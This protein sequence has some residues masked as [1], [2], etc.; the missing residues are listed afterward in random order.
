M[1]GMEAPNKF[2][3]GSAESDDGIS[4]LVVAS[5]KSAEI[6]R[7]G[8]AG[9]NENQIVLGIYAQRG[10]GIACSSVRIGDVGPGDGIPGPAHFAGASVQCADDAA[11]N[12]YFPVIG[13]G[14][15]GNHQ[16]VGDGGS[17]GD[18]ITAAPFG[19]GGGVGGEIE[20]A[21]GS[22]ISAR[23]A[24]LCVEGDEARIESAEE[25]TQS[26]RLAGLGFGVAPCGDAARGYFRIVTR[27]VYVRI[28]IPNFFAGSGIERENFVVGRSEK[29][30]VVEEDGSGFKRRFTDES[31]FELRGAS[32]KGPGDFQLRDI[33]AGDL[34]GG[35]IA[36]TAGI[37]SVGI[38]SVTGCGWLLRESARCGEQRHEEYGKDANRMDVLFR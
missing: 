4:P 32:V 5:A 27:E 17:G 1:N 38:P 33:F 7:A 36:R 25:N 20:D 14:R 23:L 34:R 31:G 28:E 35:G 37:A 11:T 13:D 10:P 2:A 21:S 16:I 26:A 9:G 3:G 24:G 19:S 18:L 6:I 12:V 15:T 29:E 30:F 22:K 8:A